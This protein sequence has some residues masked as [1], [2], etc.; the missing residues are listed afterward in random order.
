MFTH[1][2]A[3]QVLHCLTLVIECVMAASQREG[4]I[5]KQNRFVSMKLEEN[6]LDSKKTGSLL[7]GW[8]NKQKHPI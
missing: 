5:E 2:G 7:I 3:D 8:Q 1:L 6:P 4:R